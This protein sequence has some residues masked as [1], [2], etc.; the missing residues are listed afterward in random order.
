MITGTMT[1]RRLARPGYASAVPVICCG[2]VTVGGAGKTTLVIDLLR[3]LT[4][5]GA[6]PHALTRGYGGRTRHARRVTSADTA[7][8]VGDEPLLLAREAPCWVGP[9]RGASARLAEAEGADVLVLDDGLQNP[10]LRKD[11]ALLVIDG[12]VGFG[13]G[14]KL[15][16]GPLREDVATAAR[17]CRAAVLIGA[18]MTGAL[19]RLP[20]SLP[21]L[22][23][24]LAQDPAIHALRGQPI[25]AFAGIARPEKFFVPLASAGADLR[26]R[27]AFADHHAFSAGDLE[28]LSKRAAELGATLV[29][30]PKDAVRLPD[31]FRDTVTVIGVGLA[32]RD[33]EQLETLLRDTMT[34]GRAA[35]LSRDVAP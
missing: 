4:A 22:R 14:H 15:P 9:D 19:A 24:E 7:S 33:L 16:A 12:A 28:R 3:R 35:G 10:S 20:A 1:R 23:A 18:D 29:T 34:R 25:V 32:W 11:C 2:N 30:T 27:V 31:A 17:R 5:M 21:V 8:D 26:L 13:N 6:H